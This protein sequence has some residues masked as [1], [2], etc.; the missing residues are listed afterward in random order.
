MPPKLDDLTRSGKITKGFKLANP[1]LKPET[2]TS[3][4]W[5]WNMNLSNKLNFQPSVYY[6]LGKDFQYFVATGDSVDTGGS[7]LKPVLQRQNISEAEIL[8]AEITISYKPFKTLNIIGAYA[9]NN[10]KIKEF[11]SAN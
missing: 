7:S 9:F 6:S 3:Y 5:G 10:S 1:E 2:I 8:G 11:K 4:E